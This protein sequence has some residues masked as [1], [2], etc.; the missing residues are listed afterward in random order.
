MLMTEA[1]EIKWN[2][3]VLLKIE[4]TISRHLTF[5]FG[6]SKLEYCPLAIIALIPCIFFWGI[7]PSFYANLIKLRT[8]RNFE[9]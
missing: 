7:M 9:S 5:R 2:L 1:R 6:P 4:S 3:F 8:D